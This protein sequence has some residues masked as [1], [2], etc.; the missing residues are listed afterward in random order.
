VIGALG[1]NLASGHLN[2]LDQALGSR[3]R[4]KDG[5]QFNEPSGSGRHWMKAGTHS[6]WQ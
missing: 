5:E 1:V 6:R 2:S 3:R 4:S